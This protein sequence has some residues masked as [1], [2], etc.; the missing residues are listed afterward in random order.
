MNTGEF[1]RLINF[2]NCRTALPNVLKLL[3]NFILIK[4]IDGFNSE[5]K[6]KSGLEATIT[7]VTDSLIT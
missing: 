6:L 4:R 7:I 1:M 5:A 2:D 3:G